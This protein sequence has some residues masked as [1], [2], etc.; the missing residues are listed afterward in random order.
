MII[1]YQ[2][3]DNS[4]SAVDGTLESGDEILAINNE[5]VRGHTKLQ[6]AQMIQSSVVSIICVFCFRYISKIMYNLHS[7]DFY[8]FTHQDKVVLK[9]NKL[10][11][12]ARQGKTLDIVLKKVKHRL[13][14]RMSATT[15]DSLGMS[16]AILVN[17][18]L[19]KRLQQLDDME[20]S[21]RHLVDHT[22]RV[23]RAFYALTQC[24]KGT[25]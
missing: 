20:Q 11:A 9:Y 8:L 7:M 18:S 3:S 1:L 12:D 15:A 16:R 6:V 17:D 13:V 4:P 19:V 2:V 23:L 5:C 10:H 21:Y 14:E 22:E 24:F 25:Y